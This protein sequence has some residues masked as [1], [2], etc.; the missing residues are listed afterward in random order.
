MSTEPAKSTEAAEADLVY[1]NCGHNDQELAPDGRVIRC[2]ECGCI[3]DTAA[4]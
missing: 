1:R 2:L 3:W 4:R